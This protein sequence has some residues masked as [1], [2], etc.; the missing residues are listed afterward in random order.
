LNW[1]PAAK[2]LVVVVIVDVPKARVPLAAG[3]VPLAQLLPKFHSALAGVALQ[4]V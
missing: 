4:V 3:A 2:L 1:V